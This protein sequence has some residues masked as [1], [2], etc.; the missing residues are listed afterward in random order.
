[1]PTALFYTCNVF[2]WVSLPQSRAL[3]PKNYIISVP[4]GGGGGAAALPMP[5]PLRFVRLCTYR[6]R[7][8]HGCAEIWN[9]SSSVVKY[10]A[11]ECSERVQ[12]LK[13]GHIPQVKTRSQGSTDKQLGQKFPLNFVQWSGLGDT[14]YVVHLSVAQWHVHWPVTCVLEPLSF[15]SRGGVNQYCLERCC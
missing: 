11:S 10:F 5:H 14:F 1:M 7:I 15:T 13:L 9:F 3:C 8:L 6:S 4:G 2:S 12:Y